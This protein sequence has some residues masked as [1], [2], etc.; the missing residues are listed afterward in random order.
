M[1]E[2]TEKVLATF[3]DVAA[4]RVET[5]VIRWAQLG[6]TASYMG[7]IGRRLGF[8]GPRSLRRSK[9]RPWLRQ[10]KGRAAQ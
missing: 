10:K 1:A 2:N 9:S 8:I 6:R 3:V 4:N 7:C 5:I